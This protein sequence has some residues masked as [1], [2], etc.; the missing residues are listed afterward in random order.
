MSGFVAGRW[1]R[2]WFAAFLVAAGLSMASAVAA[3]PRAYATVIDVEFDTSRFLPGFNKA[4]F[5][6]YSDLYEFAPFREW[7]GKFV[8]DEQVAE[9]RAAWQ[10]EQARV[11]REIAR[12]EADDTARSAFLSWRE[13]NKVP[14]LE[15]L[16]LVAVD[17]HPPFRIYVQNHA[18]A[19]DF[20]G[21]VSRQY[22]PLLTALA[23]DFS[24]HIAGPLER[25]RQP[26]LAAT[27]VCVLRSRSDYEAFMRERRPQGLHRGAASYDPL[28]RVVVTY[29]APPKSNA[30]K[31][32]VRGLLNQTAHA[33]LHA[34]A[35]EGVKPSQRRWLTEGIAEYLASNRAGG[36]MDAP[37]GARD[38]ALVRALVR[39]AQKP[40][41]PP[42]LLL[43]SIDEL[44]AF[45]GYWPMLR[46]FARHLRQPEREL[47]SRIGFALY[48]RVYSQCGALVRFWLAGPSPDMRARTRTWVTAVLAGSEQTAAFEG[49]FAGLRR[50]DLMIEFERHLVDE[51]VA[52]KLV[53]GDPEALAAAWKAARA[54]RAGW[55]LETSASRSGLTA[56][57]PSAA[58]ATD[59]V[60]GT[61]AVDDPALLVAD[62]EGAEPRLARVVAMAA[63]GCLTDAIALCETCRA[64]AGSDGE[65]QRFELETTRLRALVELRDHVIE[66]W[67]ATGKNLSIRFDGR[68]VTGKIARCDDAIE[69]ETYSGKIVPVPRIA[70]DPGQVAAWAYS[71]KIAVPKRWALGYANLVSGRR[72]SARRGL[73]KDSS[74]EAARL[75]DEADRY[76]DRRRVAPVIA[77]LEDLADLGRPLG[78][79]SADATLNQLRGLL[80]EHAKHP[81]V[82]E[83]SGLLRGLADAAL[84]IQARKV[85]TGSLGL[86][87]AVE[88]QGDG[89]IRLSYDFDDAAELDDFRAFTPPV[90]S[91]A[92]IE[93]AIAPVD[94]RVDVRDGAVHIHGVASLEHV[95]R[96]ARPIRIGYEL[97][98]RWLGA[99]NVPP[100]IWCGVVAD[101]RSYF[102]NLN[103]GDLEAM[104]GPGQRV[105]TSGGVRKVFEETVYEVLM[106]ADEGRLE[107]AVDGKTIDSVGIS[108][109]GPGR[110]FLAQR[111]DVDAVIHSLWIEG[112]IDDD[113][114]VTVRDDWV[115]SEIETLFAGMGE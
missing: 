93:I 104:R 1:S 114:L 55:D 97:G 32:V 113:S 50:E 92:D 99:D 80:A 67:R 98:Y 39:D 52:A 87:A 85:G 73:R 33:L 71:K 79:A 29:F 18:T 61:P 16:D 65:R 27:T 3:A 56:T 46:R 45:D 47:G 43:F 115:R 74:P 17:D 54:S 31:W 20:A 76:E 37:V 105:G 69:L 63:K 2:V 14:S 75:L 21:T 91:L 110:L 12:I 100:F 108:G 89:V 30:G 58:A 11:E 53:H 101:D 57:G 13:I 107:V 10:E 88:E 111:S 109:I 68:K 72:D 38:S 78:S 82:V 6:E 112:S 81:L 42:G 41:P 4:L 8:A 35:D 44:A 66:T 94:H 77:A 19:S 24:E 15:K 62:L 64:T 51:A 96:M 70:F 83:R 34:H 106:T 22:G 9:L 26:D 5:S 48:E 102:S 59:R 49:A 36:P 40:P 60:G 84:R 7:Q 86:Q 95:V 25:E 103:L 90:D 23:Q 28:M